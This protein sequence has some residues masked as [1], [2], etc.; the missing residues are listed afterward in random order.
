M[1]PAPV[2]PEIPLD[3]A[4]VLVAPATPTPVP[5]ATSGVNTVGPEA[6]PVPSIMPA[7]LGN[8]IPEVVTSVPLPAAGVAFDFQASA[9]SPTALM[10]NFLDIA[11][12]DY[13]WSS[14]SEYFAQLNASVPKLMTGPNALVSEPPAPTPV[15]LSAIPT[16][17]IPP[18]ASTPVIPP[19]VP[20]PVI[21]Y[22]EPAPQLP[23]LPATPCPLSGGLASVNTVNAS[24]P[25]SRSGR[26]ITASKK[27]EEMNKIG[28]PN[29]RAPAGKENIPPTPEARPA[30]RIAAEAHLMLTDYGAEWE[31]CVKA[32]IAVENTI[33]SAGSRSGLPAKLQPDEW[34]KWIA[35]SSQGSSSY[36]ACPV[37]DDPLEFGYAVMAWWKQLQPDFRASPDDVL[38]RPIY[39]LP[40]EGTDP[41]VTLRKG[42]PNGLVA[43]MTLLLWWRQAL[44]R[45][46]HWQDDSEP[47][48]T[49]LVQDVQLCLNKIV[50]MPA[51]QKRKRGA[52]ATTS[53]KRSKKNG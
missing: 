40:V 25:H 17:V 42:G 32:W 39:E 9:A 35:R 18:V 22:A 23:V 50:S 41:W 30:W 5:L 43:M 12:A 45:R 48:W 11:L 37:I 51:A 2:V 53:S 19:A 38:P 44:G 52:D 29:V 21:P 13:D 31:N 33:T 24:F 34:Q 20:A 8:A 3:F 4:P 46:T 28:G 1:T 36:E 16:P 27:A 14:T 10:D 15:I 7:P 47:F 6:L 49:R 26:Q